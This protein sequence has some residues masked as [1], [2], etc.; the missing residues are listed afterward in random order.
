MSFFPDVKI[1]GPAFQNNSQD[2]QAQTEEIVFDLILRIS[3]LKMQ[4][5]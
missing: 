2:H 5:F 3:S 4:V 1:F